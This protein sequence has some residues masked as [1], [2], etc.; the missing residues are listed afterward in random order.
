MLQWSAILTAFVV[1]FPAELPDKTMF[2][3]VA[4]S[5]R[6]HRPLAV[7]TG[8]AGAFT[9]HMAL[10]AALGGVISRLPK[11]PVYAAV[12]VLFLVGAVVMWREGDE[13]D[14]PADDLPPEHGFWHVAGASFAVV[15]LA[16]F[17][18]LTQLATAS[19]AARSGAPGSTA[20][21]A[22][23]AL[24]SV[25]AIAVVAGR[26]VL[27]VLPVQ[28]VRRIAAVIFVALAVW[29]VVEIFRL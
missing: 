18:D 7:W 21:G 4:L 14:D 9:V 25:A 8:V 2:A 15:G 23:L 20:I 26:G 19:L 12:A 28:T 13:E 17:G 11:T 27:K 1:V 6:Y 16:E 5:T 22:V 24:W 3:S 29:T 10:A